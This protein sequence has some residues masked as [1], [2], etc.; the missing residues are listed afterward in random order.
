MERIL[1]SVLN[2]S[3]T[4]SFVILAVCVARLLLKKAPKTISYALWAVVAF[5]LLVPFSFESVFSLL[6]IKPE[7]IPQDIV[8]QAQ[9]RIDSGINII[10]NAVSSYLPAATPAT[11][12]INPMQIIL[13][14]GSWLWLL[15]IAVMLIYSFVTIYLLSRRLSGAVLI[16]DNIYEADNIKTPFVL[17]FMRP[18]IYIPAEL[19]AEEKGYIIL[20]EQTHIRRRDHIVKLIAYFTL[21]LHWFNPFAW[22]SFVLM[23]TDMEL[24]CDERVLK[25]L[26]TG[27]KKDYSASLLSLSTGHRIINGSPLAFGEGGIKTRIKNVLKFKNTSRIIIIVAV[28][29]VAVLSIGLAANHAQSGRSPEP[30]LYDFTAFSVNNVTIRTDASSINT[31]ELTPTDRFVDEYEVQFEELRYHTTDGRITKFIVNVYDEGAYIPEVMFDGEMKYIPHNLKTLE[32]VISYLSDYGEDGWYDRE[33]RLRSRTYDDVSGVRST[34]TKVTFVYTDGDDG[35]LHHRL[36]WVIVDASFPAARELLEFEAVYSNETEYSYT[37][38]FKHDGILYSDFIVDGEVQSVDEIRGLIEIGFA[39]GNKEDKYRIFE[40]DGYSID[41]FIVVQDSGFMNPATIYKSVY[42]SGN[43]MTLDDVRALA[44]KGD[45]LQ[46]TD[47]QFLRPSLLSSTTGGYNPTL[48]GVEGGYRL[49]LNFNETLNPEKGIKSVVL[50]S[51]WGYGEGGIDIRYS[52]VD[53]FIRA[54]PSSPA[55]TVEEAKTIAQNHLGCAVVY[56]DT[57]WWEYADEFPHHSKDPFKQALNESLD[58]IGEATYQYTD[59]DGTFIAIGKRYGT[60]YGY[61]DGTWNTVLPINGNILSPDILE[62]VYLG[63]MN[64]EV[65]ALFGE[66][67][68]HASGLMWYG[69]NDIGVFD[70]SFGFNGLIERI[71]L[72]NG[73]SWSIHDLISTAVKQQSN[74]PYYVHDG[75]YPTEAHTILSL[76]ADKDGFTVYIM[77]LWMTFLPDGEYNVRDVGG[78]HSPLALTFTKNRNGDYE[79]MEYWQPNDGAYYMSSIRSKFPEDTWNKVDTQLYI[80]AHNESCYDQAMYFFVGAVPHESNFGI[81]AGNATLTQIADNTV[82]NE[83][84]M[85]RYFP[86][87]RLRIAAYNEEIEAGKPGNWT[88]EYIDRSKNITVGKDGIDNVMITEDVIGVY[89]TESGRYAMQFELYKKA[90]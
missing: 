78:T 30:G 37:L 76:D 35:G 22:L 3:F 53:E 29:L 77:S 67:D 15:G 54:N 85:I 48:Y 88:I 2:M 69:Y 13:T 87:A 72:A 75:A 58:T 74:G 14:V 12:S 17:G 65:Y 70:P 33:Q 90:D 83:C 50:E 57:D 61:N 19:K 16:R 42:L 34:R 32:Q 43:Q 84:F 79:L 86:E 21:C 62:K 28:I 36:V 41:E 56:L 39:A 23:G 11:S 60:M 68:F 38:Q 31:A 71:S 89:N 46:Y 51:I 27:I 40:R 8:Y 25:E 63:M 45:A 59:S 10:D 9:P 66:P 20:H 44:A 5:R 47:F 81:G 1:L 55:L 52:N 26:G 64:E 6:P 4:A 7:P 24:S 82:E 73:W 18:K 80:Q 49:L